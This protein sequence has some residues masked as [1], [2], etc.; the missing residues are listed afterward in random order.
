MNKFDVLY[1]KII[2]ETTECSFA[3]NKSNDKL[4]TFF[5]KKVRSNKWYETQ[6]FDLDDFC[7]KNFHLKF[8]KCGLPEKEDEYY[9]VDNNIDTESYNIY[10]LNNI[11][12]GTV[13]IPWNYSME[14]IPYH[15]IN[16]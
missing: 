8:Y 3:K 11:K 16:Y 4:K 12:V 13:A 15:R 6:A 10:S 2:K 9:P 14:L 7:L 1:N 5:Y